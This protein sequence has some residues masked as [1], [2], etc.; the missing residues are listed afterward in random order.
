[1]WRVGVGTHHGTAGGSLHVL[2]LLSADGL[3]ERASVDLHWALLL[4]HAVCGTRA[5]ALVG[6]DL[7]E[8]GQPV[9]TKVMSE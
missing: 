8:R 5:L 9:D 7:A 2:H 6:V 1:M 3:D 4:A